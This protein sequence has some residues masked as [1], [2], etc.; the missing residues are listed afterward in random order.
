MPKD[1]D[2]DT[3]ML[4]LRGRL[5]AYIAHSRNDPRETTAKARETFRRSFE[6]RVDPDGVLPEAERRRRAESLRK[7]HYTRLAIKSVE[8]RRARRRRSDA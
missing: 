6:L 5:G 1:R 2:I 3:E 4:A 8:A 7:A